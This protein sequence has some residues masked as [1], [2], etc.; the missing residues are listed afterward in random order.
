MSKSTG[1]RAKSAG[2]QSIWADSAPR[3]LLAAAVIIAIIYGSLYPF[4]FHAAGS[5]LQ[6]FLHLAGTWKQPPRGRGDF[7]A[8]LLLYAPLGLTLSLALGERRS[9]IL[10]SLLALVMG[11][12][13]SLAL[14]LAQFYDRSRVSVLSDVYLNAVGTLIGIVVAWIGGFGP[15]KRWWPSGSMPAFARLLLLAWLGWR[16]YPYAP[17]IDLHKYWH[18]IQPL[19]SAPPPLYDIFRYGV[20]WLGTLFL[21]QTAFQPKRPFWLFLAATLC[22]L[23]AK[24]VIVSQSLSAAETIGAGNGQRGRH[25]R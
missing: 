15:S 6:D 16:L 17:T 25:P 9:P 4:Q 1:S 24:I 18:A 13:L 23:A 20:L 10:A 14:E 3:L 2:P 5:P 12:L 21:L 19:L 8:N 11:A 22:F 7:L